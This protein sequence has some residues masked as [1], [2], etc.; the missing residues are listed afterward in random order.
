MARFVRLQNSFSA[1][2]LL[3]FLAA[4]FCGSQFGRA[5]LGV[6]EGTLSFEIL[7]P[8]KSEIQKLQIQSKSDMI[9]ELIIWV[10]QTYTAS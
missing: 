6:C 9:P 1:R 5:G 7:W 2:Y 8:C 10:N 3:T 4:V